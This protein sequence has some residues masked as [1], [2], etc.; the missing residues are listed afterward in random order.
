M[1]NASTTTDLVVY[2]GVDVASRDCHAV[3]E[4]RKPRCFG[5]SAEGAGALCAWVRQ[6]HPAAEL[7][8]VMEH[9][10]VYSLAWYFLL[11]A[12]GIRCALCHASKIH[13][14]AKADGQRSK[15][16]KADAKAI[17]SYA[18][19]YRPEPTTLAPRAQRQVA[20]LLKQRDNIIEMRVALQNQFTA[21]SFLP[22]D[23]ALVEELFSKLLA[24]LAQAEADL[25]TKIEAVISQ[26]VRLREAYQIVRQLQGVGPVSGSTFCSMLDK[27]LDCNPKELTA[28]CGLAP[29]HK[30]SGNSQKP[31]H[32]DKQGRAQT[33]RNLYLAGLA[34]SKYNPKCI[35]IKQ[36]L[37]ARG[38]PRK[39]IIVAI[40]RNLLLQTQKALK[41]HFLS[42][43]PTAC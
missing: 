38:K 11:Q 25:A 15:T 1:N 29:A 5:L 6:T 8:A 21:L 37:E 32:I 19:H 23:L 3:F 24:G 22:E 41:A 28:L 14:F 30:Q 39:V 13:H 7:C 33:R 35:E 18:L 31:S 27:I 16:D 36:R 2:I 4:G 40:A 20:L 42:T 9:T 10:G 26:D 17:L 43:A 34:A 12:Q